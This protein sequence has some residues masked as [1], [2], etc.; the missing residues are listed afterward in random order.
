MK[1]QIFTIMFVGLTSLTFAQ[2]SSNKVEINTEN[3]E[4]IVYA[5]QAEKDEQCAPRIQALKAQMDKEGLSEENKI[6]LAELIWRFENAIVEE[7]K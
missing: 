3:L 2:Q 4:P 1:R 7:K 6:K 5:T